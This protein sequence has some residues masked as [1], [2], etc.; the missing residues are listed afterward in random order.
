MGNGSPRR[1]DPPLR[2]SSRRVAVACQATL[3][4]LADFDGLLTGSASTEIEATRARYEQAL[5]QAR[6]EPIQSEDDIWLKCRLY[7]RLKEGLGSEDRQVRAFGEMLIEQ[8]AGCLKPVADLPHSAFV[9]GALVNL[10][11]SVPAVPA[12]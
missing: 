7:C 3:S 1:S 6:D 12:E 5:T 8:I 4:A 2:K 10:E 9:N 11:G